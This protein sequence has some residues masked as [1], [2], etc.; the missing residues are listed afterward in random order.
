VFTST[1][2]TL[3]NTGDYIDFILEFTDTYD[4]TTGVSQNFLGIGLFNSG[5][6]APLT[7]NE[8]S[9]ATGS[10]TG[11]TQGWTGYFGQ[12][13]GFGATG[14][15]SSKTWNR[16][17]QTAAEGDQTLLFES[18]SVTGGTGSP[19]AT[20]L[21]NGSAAG[22]LNLTNGAQYTEDFRI[23]LTGAGQ[24]TVTNTIYAGLGTGGAV[25]T[26]IGGVSNNVP[27]TTFDSLA[28]GVEGKS[29]LSFTQDVSLVEITTDIVP[30]PSSWMLLVS[31]LA[32]MVGL[33]A[34]RRRN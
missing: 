2:L 11:G 14:A 3:L 13:A 20:Q 26:A 7:T 25:L 5:G 34:R 15:N 28:F 18:G 1:P 8:N 4:V 30:E 32:V 29:S 31:G 21:I 17:A 16:S 33:V 23:T 19:K 12:L 27:S 10:A 24:L 6:V 9:G 22:T